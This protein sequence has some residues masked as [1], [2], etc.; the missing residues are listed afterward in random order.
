MPPVPARVVTI[1]TTSTA[2]QRCLDA[3]TELGVKSFSETHVG[4]AGV[5]GKKRNTLFETENVEFIVV[6]SAALA[7][8]LLDW[9]EHNLLPHW[10]MIAYSADVVAIAARPMD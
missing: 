8:R 9:V 4:G 1:I 10:P 3:F 5:H 2:R 7:L 6:S